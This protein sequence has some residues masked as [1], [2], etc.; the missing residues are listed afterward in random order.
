M[1]ILNAEPKLSPTLLQIYKNNGLPLGAAVG[2]PIG[3]VILAAVLL[4]LA[5]LNRKR[6]TR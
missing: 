2:V 4:Y 6:T 3:A 5:H 1:A